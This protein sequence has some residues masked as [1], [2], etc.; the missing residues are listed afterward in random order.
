MKRKEKK[1]SFCFFCF[2]IKEKPMTATSSAFDTR[3]SLLVQSL[4]FAPPATTDHLHH[5]PLL[6]DKS[7]KGFIDVPIAHLVSFVN[8]H[9]DLCTTSSCSGRIALFMQ[10]E[11]GG[12]G[13]SGQWILCSHCELQPPS[14]GVLLSALR[15][16]F[17]LSS[18]SSTSTFTST[19]SPPL[20]LSLL[21]EPFL[22][23]I[24]CRT[25]QSAHY[26]LQT[27][28]ESGLR[29]SGIISITAHRVIVRVVG[30]MRMEVPLF[31]G[32]DRELV[33]A[34]RE[35][36]VFV[37]PHVSEQHLCLLVATANG[38]MRENHRQMDRFTGVFRRQFRP[39]SL[40][41]ATVS[42]G[43]SSAVVAMI[44][45]QMRQNRERLRRVERAVGEITEAVAERV[46]V[47]ATKRN[48]QSDSGGW[49]LLLP[50]HLIPP[51]APHSPADRHWSFIPINCHFA[52]FLRIRAPAVYRAE[53]EKKEVSISGHCRE[54][55]ALRRRLITE[56]ESEGDSAI[57][58]PS[59][60]LLAGCL[61]LILSRLQWDSLTREFV[62][63][64]GDGG[65]DVHIT[66]HL[67]TPASHPLFFLA[68][69][70][71]S[72][73][74]H[75]SALSL[76]LSSQLHRQIL[77][78]SRHSSHS[79]WTA[80]LHLVV[81]RLANEMDTTAH[82]LNPLLSRLISCFPR[83]KFERL[84]DCVLLP[85]SFTRVLQVMREIELAVSRASSSSSP[86]PHPPD[87]C[88]LVLFPSLLSSL[89]CSQ[90][91]LQQP[92][93]RGIERASA[94]R[95]LFDPL[96]KGGR[97]VHRENGIAYAIDVTRAMFSSGNLTEKARMAEVAGE[98]ETV[99]D[100]FA[101]IGYF[102]LPL[103]VHAR[104][105]FC[106]CC[107][108]T[109]SSA[110][111]L[112]ENMRLNGV[113]EGRYRVLRGLNWETTRAEEVVGCVDRVCLGMLP[114]VDRRAY[115]AGMRALRERGG[116][117]HVHRCVDVEGSFSNALKHHQREFAGRL[118]RE[119]EGIAK[120]M[121]R[122]WRL[123]AV[124]CQHV[125]WFAPRV[126]HTVVDVR[127]VQDDGQ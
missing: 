45:A 81:D 10:T 89:R 26:L 33:G 34:Q 70:C 65:D 53:G 3:K 66:P 68:G 18:S 19:P 110:A 22:L 106:F 73:P 74:S 32:T 11:G 99:L 46:A 100:L 50:K 23:H 82:H 25:L 114:A 61:N 92:V 72:F 8:G 16:S 51:T 123:Q 91:F 27:A 28:R 38:K 124:H 47:T 40:L 111:L 67:L 20:S 116:W 98:G 115:V 7:P 29:E 103:L 60:H 30:T 36:Q 84:G 44:D 69:L 9:P 31:R 118:L 1:V 121:G 96:R 37:I 77:L 95:V 42:A 15:D 35:C 63:Q 57:H 80:M 58:P 62:D 83:G 97:V 86:P 4:Q 5:P 109:D 78:R 48:S 94:A 102:S 59:A 39:L 17:P 79:Q 6:P 113:D 75:S 41:A 112:E 88:S 12:G 43:A 55:R 125:K 54:I 76:R 127:V 108:L 2:K 14:A 122:K 107:E 71:P 90:L 119:L 52:R 21:F 93:H 24:D 104:V 120:Q 85:P 101:G 117:M 105:R 13:G 126:S 87:L 49:C 56:S 64:H